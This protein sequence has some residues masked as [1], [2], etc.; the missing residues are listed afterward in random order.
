MP[1]NAQ[2]SPQSTLSTFVLPSPSNTIRSLMRVLTIVLPSRLASVTG[3]PERSV[4]RVSLP[5][6][7]RPT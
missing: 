5:T 6:A 2:I 7:I 3:M 4:P 1:T